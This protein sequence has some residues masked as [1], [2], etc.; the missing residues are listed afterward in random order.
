MPD[1]A[2]L[3]P[4]PT[5]LVVDPDV[6]TARAIVCF[7]EKRGFHVAAGSTL[8]DV[9][10]FLHRRKTWTLVIADY[11]LPDGNGVE[12]RDWMDQEG[13][14]APLLLLSS[15]PHCETPC[16]GIQYLAKPFAIEKLDQ[17]VRTVPRSR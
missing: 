5:L 1:D 4:W 15:N 3:L 11:Y 7:F 17:Y 10:D 14:R 6:A 9:R 16:E 8:A 12:V 13:C 2:R